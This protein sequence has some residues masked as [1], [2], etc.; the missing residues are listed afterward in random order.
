MRMPERKG[1]LIVPHFSVAGDFGPASPGV[2]KINFQPQN[3]VE[4]G[5]RATTLLMEGRKE[6]KEGVREG[7]GRKGRKKGR[8]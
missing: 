8:R 1:K 5:L 4:K 6:G 2:S 3:C 7:E